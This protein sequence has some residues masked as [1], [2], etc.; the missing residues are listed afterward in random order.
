MPVHPVN[1]FNPGPGLM[2]PVLAG[3]ESEQDILRNVLY[4]LLNGTVAPNGILLSGPR[5]MGKTVLLA[6]FLKEA[7]GKVDVLATSAQN[8]ASIENLALF[9]DPALTDKVRSSGSMVGANITRRWGFL[10]VFSGQDD[11]VYN[12]SGH[13]RAKIMTDHPPGDS[14]HARGRPLIICG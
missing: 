6:W 8:I 9:V 13:I 1:P 12:W 2:P 5:G 7:N 11:S 14:A 10:G 3:R 4:E